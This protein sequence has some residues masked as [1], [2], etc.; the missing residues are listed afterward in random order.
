MSL[1]V[2]LYADAPPTAPKN[3]S[4]IFIRRNGETVEISR[5][6]WDRAFPGQE[7]VVMTAE[8]EADTNVYSANIT[9]NLNK[10]ADAA[11]IYQAMWRPEEIGAVRAK[12]IIELLSDGLTKL[13]ADP[14]KFKQFDPPNKWGSYDG[15]VRF[16]EKY[17]EA[18]R[19]YPEAR[20]NV[21]R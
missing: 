5:E 18:C 13:R 4:G 8:G 14:D 17:L 11:G 7:P 16:A 9:H 19:E 15:L 20:I 21:S 12:D 2:Y 1:D 6:E 3:G 10:M